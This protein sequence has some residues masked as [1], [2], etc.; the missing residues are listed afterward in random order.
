MSFGAKY[1]AVLVTATRIR[2]PWSAAQRRERL[3]G[4]L[5]DAEHLAGVAGEL[6]ARLR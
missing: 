2:P 5:D 4:L 3:V 1:F 6:L